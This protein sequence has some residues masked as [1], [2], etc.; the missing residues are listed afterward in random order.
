MV[1]AQAG[2]EGEIAD[3]VNRFHIHAGVDFLRVAQIAQKECVRLDFLM[4]VIDAVFQQGM[5]ADAAVQAHIGAFGGD[6]GFGRPGHIAGIAI[7]AV[8]GGIAFVFHQIGVGCQFIDKAQIL[9]RPLEVIVFKRGF[10]IGRCL[11]CQGQAAVGYG[12]FFTHQAVAAMLVLHTAQHKTVVA[13]ACTQFGQIAAF[14]QCAIRHGVATVDI[15]V[16]LARFIVVFIVAAVG[17][18]TVEIARSAKHAGAVSVAVVAGIAAVQAHAPVFIQTFEQIQAIN[19][20]GNNRAVGGTNAGTGR[21]RPFLYRHTFQQCRVNDKTALMIEN[22]AVGIGIVHLDVDRILPHTANRQKLRCAVAAAEID[23]RFFFQQ[24]AQ[25]G[26]R[27]FI[28]F[29]HR[30]NIGL[31]LHALAVAGH[32]YLFQ[33][34]NLCFC[35]G[36]RRYSKCIAD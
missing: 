14:I 5:P 9:R 3:V 10:T 18:Q 35:I 6:G 24:S 23:G 21:T 15:G 22:L 13:E 26:F 20:F 2:G 32:R 29:V 4:A 34:C 1:V 31:N 36:P 19:G 33:F 8:V 25:V 16:A 30:Y 7:A 12:K 27:A 11:A 28:H 17:K